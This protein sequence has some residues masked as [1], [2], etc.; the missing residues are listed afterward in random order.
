MGLPSASYSAS[1]A[2]SLISPG[3]KHTPLDTG[4]F[5]RAAPTGSV[6]V[7]LTSTAPAAERKRVDAVPAAIA[8]TVFARATRIKIVSIIRPVLAVR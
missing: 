6:T 1:R 2:G 5:W 8:A 3:L 7:S 4:S